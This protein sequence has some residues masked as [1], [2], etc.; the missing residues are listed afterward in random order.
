MK[1]LK[2]VIFFIILF[3][4]LNL[5]AQNKNNNIYIKRSSLK[6]TSYP[7]WVKEV[8]TNNNPR[9]ITY[10]LIKTSG[11]KI[12]EFYKMIGK[13]S[14]A[15]VIIASFSPNKWAV[16]MIGPTPIYTNLLFKDFMSIDPSGNKPLTKAMTEQH[17]NANHS[18][19]AAYMD[20]Y[21]AA[22]L[23]G[24]DFLAELDN[25]SISNIKIVN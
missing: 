12:T 11:G 10:L 6:N 13:H 24:Q 4:S 17:F 5:N 19:V 16:A 15:A 1:N 7:Y 2:L 3:L 8:D 21:V 22:A 20:L 25:I 23:T 9:I 14:D 18:G